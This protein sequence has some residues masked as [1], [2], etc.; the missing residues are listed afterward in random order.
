M[1]LNLAETHS[2]QAVNTWSRAAQ[3]ATV[4]KHPD[5]LPLRTSVSDAA[6]PILRWRHGPVHYPV[7]AYF[8]AVYYATSG[9]AP[10]KTARTPKH[11]LESRQRQQFGALA[12]ALSSVSARKAVQQHLAPML[13][14]KL[15]A[16]AVIPQIHHACCALREDSLQPFPSW[17]ACLLKPGKPEHIPADLRPISLTDAGGGK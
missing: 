5:R 15:A 17:L 10:S 7:P 3:L 12:T 1:L 8:P 16:A 2:L 6:F 11:A 9:Q 14:W 13:L 4:Q